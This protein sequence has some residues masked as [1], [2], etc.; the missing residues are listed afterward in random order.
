MKET[1][2]TKFDVDDREKYRYLDPLWKILE[3]VPSDMKIT[4]DKAG[5]QSGLDP[6]VAV[7]L[8]QEFCAEFQRKMM[9]NLFSL[10]F[11]SD[12]L[13][14]SW[15]FDKV[16]LLTNRVDTGNDP[17]DDIDPKLLAMGN[18]IMRK[19]EDKWR[20]KRGV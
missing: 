19:W 12:D 11:G 6:K 7:P 20:A 9:K 2:K 8:I 10:V 15:T 17:T 16:M 5:E 18:P 3:S 14:K 13:T 4:M 1:G